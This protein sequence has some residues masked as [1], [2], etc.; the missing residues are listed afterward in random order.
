MTTVL[1]VEKPG[2]IKELNVKAFSES[3][4]YKRAGFKNAEGFK[5]Y[6]QWD[7]DVDNKK[8]SIRLFG[9]T[10]GRSMQE[11]KY[12]FPPPAD[13]ILFFGNCVLINVV[14][15]CVVS[16]DKNMWDIIY[17]KLHGGFIDTND[18]CESDSQS[19]DSDNVNVVL[20]KEGYAKDKFVVDSDDLSENS[21]EGDSP[22]LKKR[23]ATKKRGGGSSKPS[24]K[25][26][27]CP[28]S[29]EDSSN[30]NYMD[31]SVELD[32]EEYV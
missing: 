17:E 21:D 26:A 25:V 27:D 3:E 19:D 23:S 18:S 12:E 30:N 24:T 1:I 31:C 6:A 5:I 28:C 29:S 22:V 14:N 8:Q 4:L 20:T 10:T 11:N 32:E 9:K 16:L 15:D 13:N 7:I 2:T